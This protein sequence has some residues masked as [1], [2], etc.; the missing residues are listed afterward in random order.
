M[1]DAQEREPLRRLPLALVLRA[2]ALLPELLV[3]AFALVD[4]LLLAV[5]GLLDV[6]GLLDVLLLVEALG[7][8]GVFAL[9]ERV[10]DVVRERLDEV[11]RDVEEP[12]RSAAGI[13]AFA[14][15][16]VSSG[17]CFSRKDAMRSSSRRMPFASFAVSVSP[18]DSA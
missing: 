5:L 14:T 10:L 13:S 18:T 2:R 16:F 8:L 15:S 17:I 6:F 4:E 1:S 3:G 7:L 11:R 9:L 12:L